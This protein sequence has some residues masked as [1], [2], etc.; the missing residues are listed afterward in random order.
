MRK[1]CVIIVAAMATF[2]VVVPVFAASDFGDDSTDAC[3]CCQI[4]M[5][6]FEY[7]N[8]VNS[9][10]DAIGNIY[11]WA[12]AYPGSNCALIYQNWTTE[13]YYPE[14]LGQAWLDGTKAGL[15]AYQIC[16]WGSAGEICSAGC[17]MPG[18]SSYQDCSDFTSW[19][20]IGNGYEESAGMTFL[21]NECYDVG[22]N[23]YRC[24]AGYYGSS[25]NGTSGC[26]RCPSSG[27]IYGVSAAGSTSIA[28][29]Y[30]PSGK[31]MSDSVGAYT[32]TANCYYTN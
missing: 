7:W 1:G 18:M 3:T 26:T 10:S 12:S 24:A 16:D 29:C 14:G 5:D 15:S 17:E 20:D 30:I 21:C 4:L 27:G 25:T 11:T 22:E 19:N 23:K 9:I 6:N 13:G 32:Y 8:P 31:S 28:S 2:W